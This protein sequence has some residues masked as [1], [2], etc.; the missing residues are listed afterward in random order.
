VYYG[1]WTVD[2]IASGQLPDAAA[3]AGQMLHVQSP[4][5]STFLSVKWCKGRHEEEEDEEEEWQ[6][7]WH[8]EQ[9][10]HEQEE[11]DLI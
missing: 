4:A 6:E 7:Q 9:K 8:T 3:E 10:E 1:T 5:G 2:R 11:Q